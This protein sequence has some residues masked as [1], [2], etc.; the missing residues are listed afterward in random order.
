MEEGIPEEANAISQT[1]ET[2]RRNAHLWRQHN[3]TT[4]TVETTRATTGAGPMEEGLPE[5]ANA[6]SQTTELTTSRQ[7]LNNQQE[8]S[9][10]SG[11]G[12]RRHHIPLEQHWSQLQGQQQRERQ[13][14]RAYQRRPTP[15]AKRQRRP[16]ETLT[17]GDSII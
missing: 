7:N 10:T 16:G 17:C 15:L 13:W 6:I 4:V 9:R 8:A 14:K 1:T 2:A 3:L 11:M 12:S 5:E